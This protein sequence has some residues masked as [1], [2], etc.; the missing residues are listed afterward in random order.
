MDKEIQVNQWEVDMW[1]VKR[2][3]LLTQL[4]PTELDGGKERKIERE[5]KE[6]REIRDSRERSSTF[7]LD[8]PAIG[9]ANSGEAIGKV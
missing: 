9:P 4:L 1:Q 6:E 5:K 3:V 2:Q 8:F 7:S